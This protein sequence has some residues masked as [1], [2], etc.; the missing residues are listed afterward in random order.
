MQD[1]V[2]AAGD[3]MEDVMENVMQMDD[4]I[5]AVTDTFNSLW[6]SK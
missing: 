3:V 6:K 4:P 5:G 2:D 1:L